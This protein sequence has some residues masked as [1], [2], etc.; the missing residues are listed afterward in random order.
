MAKELFW[1]AEKLEQYIRECVRTGA[2]LSSAKAPSAARRKAIDF[3]GSW[4]GLLKHCGVKL[5]KPKKTK[6]NHYVK[7]SVKIKNINVAG[8]LEI[9]S[10]EG[11]YFTSLC[12]DCF[13][14]LSPKE[15]YCPWHDHLELPKNAVFFR[16]I[17][18]P[19]QK[20]MDCA[21]IVDCPLFI[22]ET[23]ELR[24]KGRKGHYR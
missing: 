22:K 19:L 14:P 2:S 6:G 9:P 1:T 8:A 5:K 13:R 24:R 23:A 10:P 20:P 16:V 12:W 17:R 21:V 15:N 11:S 3:F 18:N 4:K 7:I